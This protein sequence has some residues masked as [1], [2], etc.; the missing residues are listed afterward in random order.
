MMALWTI[1]KLASY[2]INESS[3]SICTVAHYWWTLMR[4]DTPGRWLHCVAGADTKG[5]QLHRRLTSGTWE[6]L[7]T[8][9]Q[10]NWHHGTTPPL[11]ATHTMPRFYSRGTSTTT[12]T[13]LAIMIQAPPTKSMTTYQMHLPLIKRYHF[14]LRYQR[15]VSMRRH[16][17]TCFKGV[18]PSRWRGNGYCFDGST[19]RG[20][21]SLTCIYRIARK[22]GGELNLV[23]W[24]SIL[25]PPN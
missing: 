20:N 25:Q 9:S 1:D 18:W 8:P 17:Q 7:R 4:T 23:V 3:C 13:V 5:D 19:M 2:L 14:T 11:R 24:W 12:T 15:N 16:W 6:A 21:Y 10:G 22:F